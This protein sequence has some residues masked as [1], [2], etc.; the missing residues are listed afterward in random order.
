MKINKKIKTKDRVSLVI[1]TVSLLFVSMFFFTIFQI[2]DTNDMKYEKISKV[3][4]IKDIKI[5]NEK[6]EIQLGKLKNSQNLKESALSLNMVGVSGV[7]YVSVS[8]DN[9]AFNGR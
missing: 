4:L 9:V 6:L 7:S 5:E 2:I 8:G 1:F 3:N